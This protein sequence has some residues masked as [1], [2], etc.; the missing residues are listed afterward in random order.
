[1]TCFGVAACD[2]LNV[3]QGTGD[4]QCPVVGAHALAEAMPGSHVHIEEDGGHFAY[5]ACN[6]TVRRT[7]LESLLASGRKL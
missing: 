7:A 1:M 6:E 5:F 4:R 2:V 3:V